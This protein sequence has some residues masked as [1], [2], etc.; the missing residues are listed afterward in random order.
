MPFNCFVY[1]LRIIL[2]FSTK[3]MI[4]LKF[5]VCYSLQQQ[6]CSLL[7]VGA[8]PHLFLGYNVAQLTYWK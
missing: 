2:L 8:W 1:I 7:S 4:N 3:H 6:P 5:M